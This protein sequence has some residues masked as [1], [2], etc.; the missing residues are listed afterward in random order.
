[1]I[2]EPMLVQE[3]EITGYR[4]IRR[5]RFRLRRINVITGPNG[6]GKSNLYRAL[7][8][9]AGA[10]QGG[11]GSAIAEEG[12][13]PSVL[14]AGRKQKGLDLS[15]RLGMKLISDEFCY[16]LQMG[17]SDQYGTPTA[18]GLDPSVKE[19]YVWHGLPRRP[20]ATYFERNKKGIW[21]MGSNG[22]RERFSGELDDGAPILL[23]LQEPHRYPE[24]SRVRETL[25]R[26]R[27]Y[28]HFD[29]SA[30]SP[31]RQPQP[32]VRTPVLDHAGLTLG[33]ALQTVA[34]HSGGKLHKIVAAA[35]SGAQL[36]I[37]S[38][39][40]RFC[41]ELLMPGMLRPLSARE[42]SDGTLR[43]L[44]LAAALLS[45]SPAPMLV[46]NEP[47]TSLHPDL[48]PALADLILAASAQSQIWVITHSPLLADALSALAPEMKRMELEKINGETRIVGEGL[49]IED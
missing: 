31:L 30:G 43:F 37:H 32:G 22:K 39:E 20:S 45:P 3:V 15:P 7:S 10:A 25:K 21:M 8:L 17:I 16:E 28:H 42:F 24:L 12:G 5:L 26:W 48:M 40:A 47:E 2:T 33:V 44:C 35:L 4:S 6:V 34:E 38:G 1:M 41:P 46:L 36:S 49:I 9:L 13:M 27:F 23:Q 18:F 19:E 11:L 29:T 14:W